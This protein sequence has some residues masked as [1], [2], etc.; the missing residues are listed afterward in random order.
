MFIQGGKA[1]KTPPKFKKNQKGNF[2]GKS[3]KIY[4]QYKR[5]SIDIRLW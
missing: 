2:S 3:V 5:F 4:G 1:K